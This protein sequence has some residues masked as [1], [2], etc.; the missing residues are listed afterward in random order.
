MPFLRF[1]LFPLN[2][3]IEGWGNVPIHSSHILAVMLIFIVAIRMMAKIGEIKI[4]AIGKAIL[5]IVFV[6]FISIIGVFQA[7]QNFTEYFKSLTNIFFFAMLYFAF[8]NSITR[9]DT[10]IRIFKI[11]I[12][13]SLLVA[14]YGF[15]Q[16]LGYF[17]PSLSLIPGTEIIKY[18]GIPRVSSILKE[19]VPFA[20]HLVYPIILM[21]VMLIE[22]QMFPF[23]TLKANFFALS[24]LLTSFILAFTVT[25]FLYLLIFV[26][27]F[28]LS[29]LTS[30]KGYLRKLWLPVS[31]GAAFLIVCISSDYGQVFQSRVSAALTLADSS[32]VAR[33]HSASIAWQEFFKYPL[34]GIG[35]GNFPSFTAVGLFP[36]QYF[37]IRHSDILI[38]QI[39]AEMGVIG[40][41]AILLFFGTLLT[42]LRKVIRL[43]K[44]NDLNFHISRGLY[45]MLSTYMISTLVVSGWLE[46]WAW[47]NFSIVGIWVLLEGRRLN[48]KVYENQSDVITIN[49]SNSQ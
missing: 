32:T 9:Q 3:L 13:V 7:Y 20:L 1:V 10:I 33:A 19:S 30:S 2:K 8:T 15:Y 39:L 26:L 28:S 18:G 29:N 43:N 16:L 41:I 37:E 6:Y 27:L 44:S 24:I 23:K 45:F 40:I 21:S 49:I 35:A 14:L 42:S 47:F 48:E 34:F 31:I 5:L 38:F 4:G 11:W 36:H 46:F 22:K 25:G 12:I 17:I